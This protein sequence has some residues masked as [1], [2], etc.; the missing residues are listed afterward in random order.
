MIFLLLMAG[1][2]ILEYRIKE[3]RERHK[4]PKTY[5][6]GKL[7]IVTFHNKGAFYGMGDE[8]PK[9]VKGISLII[10]AAL[11]GMFLKRLKNKE[12]D[13]TILTGFGILLGGAISN[14]YDRIKRGYVVDYINLP[15]APW[16]IKN[17]V[18]NIAD[19]AILIG[20]ILIGTNKS[21]EKQ[22]NWN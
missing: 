20:S 17:I 19:V 2:V 3:Y 16:K 22:E 8:K 1:I 11:T 14:I 21:D 9:L 12:K 18:F 13:K 6:N 7:R 15:K 4:L 5:M 10:T